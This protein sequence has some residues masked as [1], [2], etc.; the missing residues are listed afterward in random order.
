MAIYNYIYVLSL[1]KPELVT[2]ILKAAE[3]KDSTRLPADLM[4]SLHLLAI[5]IQCFITL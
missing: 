1:I 2:A 4:Q 3:E 5:A